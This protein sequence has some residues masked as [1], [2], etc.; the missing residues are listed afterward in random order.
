MISPA[1]ASA[2]LCELKAKQKAYA[3]YADYYRG[4]QPLSFSTD[5]WSQAF[6]SLFKKLAYN[7]CRPVVDAYANRLIVTG[8]ESPN[9]K[10]AETD[11]VGK[12]AQKVWE[13]VRMQKRQ[14]E[15]FTESLR[16]GDAYVIVWPDDE[17]LVRIDINRG[18]LIQPVYDDEY[19][20]RLAYAVKCWQVPTGE[21][22]GKWRVTVYEPD[23]ITRWIS[24]TAKDERPEKFQALIPFADDGYPAEI[25]NPYGAVPVFHFGNNADTGSCGTSELVDVIP[26]QDGVNKSIAD[27]LIAGEYVSFPQRWAVGVAPVI[28]P[29]TH[30]TVEQFKAAVDR[31]W[32]VDAP[33]AKFGQFDPADMTQYTQSQDAWDLKISRV[34][35]VPVHWLSMSGDFP[36]GE[37]LKTA[38]GPFTAEL[39][40]H[41]TDYG[42][43]LAAMMA[44]ALQVEGASPDTVVTPIWK[45]AETRSD[46]ET[47]ELAMMKRS[48]GIPDEQ[49][50]KEAGYSGDEIQAFTA[51]AEKKRQEQMEQFA[52]SFNRGDAEIGAR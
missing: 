33:D 22:R 7:R 45:P 32:G 37:A 29:F 34:S 25:D 5:Q 2:A 31:V 17:G 46:R 41:Q 15:L 11:P 20:E 12:L 8:W 23:G 50:W 49:I 44:F 3:K 52:Q 4:K 16:A 24:R 30:E 27:M 13:R 19:P 9:A 42:D 51:A 10:D 21:D 36:S 39:V 14:G 48:V 38:E 6:G 47:W 18:H 35:S 40:D 1:D 26:L 28:D 43:V